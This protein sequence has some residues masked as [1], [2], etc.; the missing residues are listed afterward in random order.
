[1]IDVFLSYKRADEAGAARLIGA[2]EAEGFK[3]WWDRQLPGGEEWRTQIEEAL[4][5]ARVVVVCWTRASVGIEGAFVRDEASRAGTRL[6]PVLLESVKPPLGFGEQHA[7]DLSHWRGGRRDP[8]FRDLVAVIRAKKNGLPVPPATGPSLRAFRRFAYGGGLAA[9]FFG[10]IGFFASAPA[11]RTQVCTLPVAQPHLGHFCC[12]LGFTAKSLARGEF[13][14]PRYLEKSAYL[15]Q[16]D[17]PLPT[18]GQAQA[19]ALARAEVDARDIICKT[20]DADQKLISVEV[21]PGPFECRQSSGGYV[22]A[23]NYVASC[24]ISERALIEAC[25]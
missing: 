21:Q 17:A 1:M 22:C 13:T 19:E 6:V 3:V 12:S 9:L 20:H 10:A 24:A 18:I 15:R 4:A 16:S 8:F 25:Q 14:G 7:I 23:L 11:I 5:D 2:L